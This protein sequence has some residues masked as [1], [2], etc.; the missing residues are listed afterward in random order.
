MAKTI[1]FYFRYDETYKS[2]NRKKKNVPEYCKEL[3]QQARRMML[4][5]FS[6]I[7]EQGAGQLS[8]VIDYKM[9]H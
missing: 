1:V 9:R 5:K 6:T 3:E 4:S 7:R 2:L 8:A